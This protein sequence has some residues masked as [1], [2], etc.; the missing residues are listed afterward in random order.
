MNFNYL[1]QFVDVVKLGSISKGA[2]KNHISQSALS[3]QIKLME[4]FLDSTLLERSNKGVSL[5]PQGNIVYKQSLQIITLYNKMLQDIERMQNQDKVLEI[6]STSSI[7]DYALPCTLYHIKKK[8]PQLTI[9]LSN[10]SSQ[11]IEEH[12]ACGQGTIG[13]ISGKPKNK[14]LISKKIFS[15]KICLVAGNDMSV[16]AY[17]SKEMLYDYPIIMLDSSKYIRHQLDKYLKKIGIDVS[18]LKILYSLDS[19]ES[20][21]SSSARGFGLAFLPYMTIKKEL[22]NKQLKIIEMDDF[23]LDNNF[24]TVTKP[25]DDSYDKEIYKLINYIEKTISKTIC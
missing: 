8:Y 11:L 18:N 20:I 5:T 23:K 3:Q 15:D 9:K 4:Q 24:Y 19:I 12:I 7:C 14:S 22:Y 1:S 25:L 16:P 2:E 13:F 17:L 21:K 10:M 6:F